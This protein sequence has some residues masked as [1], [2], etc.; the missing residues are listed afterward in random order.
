MRPA[1]SFHT[2]LIPIVGCGPARCRRIVAYRMTLTEGS[3]MSAVTGRQR[4]RSQWQRRLRRRP[5]AGLRVRNPPGT[6][7]SLP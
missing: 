5:T 6:W 7:I 2:I 1:I 4:S 3:K